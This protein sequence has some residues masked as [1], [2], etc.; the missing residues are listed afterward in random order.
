MT[1]ARLASL[2][3]GR[4]ALV[5]LIPYNPVTGLPYR[6]PGRAAVARFTEVLQQRGL[7][8]QVRLRKGDMIDAACG[9]LRKSQAPNPKS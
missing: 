4:S 9:Q 2:L 7:N 1:P 8:V 3:V 6:T 5:N